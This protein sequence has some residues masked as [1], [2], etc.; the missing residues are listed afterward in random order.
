MRNEGEKMPR[1]FGGRWNVKKPSGLGDVKK[2][3]GLGEP[4]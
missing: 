1:R 3:S 2:P 4:G